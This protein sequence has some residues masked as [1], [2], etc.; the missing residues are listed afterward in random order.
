MGERLFD[1]L[2]R[3]LASPMPRR[4]ALRTVGAGLAGLAFSGWRPNRA[5]ASAFASQ[6]RSASGDCPPNSKPC[7]RICCRPDFRC[8]PDARL[9]PGLPPTGACC[10]PGTFFCRSTCCNDGERCDPGDDVFEG[11]CGKKECSP[12]TFRC[13]ST[14]CPKGKKCCG[15]RC[16]SRSQKCCRDLR[17]AGTCCGKQTRCCERN[18]Q[19]LQVKG[20]KSKV[21]CLK[22]QE[23][24][25]PRCCPKG[26]DCSS[27]T[28]SGD[29][30]CCP[31]DRNVCLKEGEG[32]VCCPSRQGECCPLES[33]QLTPGKAKVCCPKGQGCCGDK[34]CADGTTCLSPGPLCCPNERVCG[35]LVSGGTYCCPSPLICVDRGTEPGQFRCA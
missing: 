26:S 14:C 4:A 30:L 28:K 24:C 23:C 15:S 29:T 25:G 20:K 8:Y 9:A 13:G 1:D 35:T 7:G 6:P 18:A 12:G 16:C 27:Y 17:G 3:A 10:P 32:I 22:G 2:S 19:R 11:R 34:C 33:Q 31:K 5:R 21:C